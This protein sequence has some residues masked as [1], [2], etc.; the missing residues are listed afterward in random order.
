MAHGVKFGRKP[1]LSPYQCEEA[2]KARK[3]RILEAEPLATR[4]RLRILGDRVHR[5]ARCA[6]QVLRLLG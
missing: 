2:L 4:L 5:A 6:A 3:T 1:K